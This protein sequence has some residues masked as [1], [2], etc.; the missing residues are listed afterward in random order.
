MKNCAADT[1]T[2]SHE[3]LPTQ[4]QMQVSTMLERN[5]RLRPAAMDCYIKDTSYAWLQFNDCATGRGY[6]LK[7][8]F[9]K[10]ESISTM[11]SALTRFDKKFVIPE[12]LRAYA[13]YSMIYVV[14][15]NTGKKEQMT[16]QEELKIDF[17]KL[18][19]TFDSV[20]VS[21]NR[22]YVVLN[23]DGKKVPL[24]KSISL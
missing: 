17:D 22:I 10:K 15:V 5:I 14:D 23:K 6:L 21:H 1:I 20:N 24:E 2:W 3:A 12:D 13:D 8:P 16:F 7:L 18:H 9:N 4:R 11:K 19:K